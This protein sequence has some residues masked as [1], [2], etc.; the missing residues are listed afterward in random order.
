MVSFLA[1]SWQRGIVAPLNHGYKQDEFEFYIDDMDVAL[2]L[3]P[4]GSFEKGGS[5]VAAATSK[6]TAI[7]ECYWN[8]ESV[9]LDVKEKGKLA[10]KDRQEAL[11]A[12]EDDIAL[13]LH[14]SGTTGRPK[15][16]RGALHSCTVLST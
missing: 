6:G 15:A 9:V 1:T 10:G 2:I 13:V 16:V 12:Q 11:V 4:K 7:A 14:T 8:G 5:A 3:I